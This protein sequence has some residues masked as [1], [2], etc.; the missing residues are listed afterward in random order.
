MADLSFDSTGVSTNDVLP[1][2]DYVMQVTAT[3]VKANSKKNGMILKVEYTI[4]EG[5][6]KGRKIFGNIN[7]KHA[8]AKAQSIGQG[9]LAALMRAVGVT[10]MQNT[11]ELHNIPFIGR[12]KIRAAQGDYDEQN[13]L[14]KWKKLDEASVSE[15]DSDNPYE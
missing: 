5:D 15:S 14:S 9:Q 1:A 7:Y 8:N 10:K 4:L 3:D 6:A 2:K 11:S 12:V 13:E